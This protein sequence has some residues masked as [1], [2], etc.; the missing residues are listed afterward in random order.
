M[1]YEYV[2]KNEYTPVRE[3]L[4]KIIKI[5]QKETKPEY[6]FQFSL[7]GSGGK[8]LITREK[9]SNKGFDFDYNFS[10]K[11]IQ[12]AYDSAQAIRSNFLDV[13]VRVAKENNYKV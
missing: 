3:K 7:I 1:A 11:K 6:T 5:I 12:E 4:E 13:I 9:G 8:K 2:S 10:L